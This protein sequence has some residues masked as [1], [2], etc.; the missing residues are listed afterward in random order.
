MFTLFLIFKWFLKILQYGE[1]KIN[2]NSSISYLENNPVGPKSRLIHPNLC[3]SVCILCSQHPRPIWA[4]YVVGL[5]I[6]IHS[7]DFLKI[8]QC[9]DIKI[10]KS[11]SIEYLENTHFDPKIGLFI[12]VWIIVFLHFILRIHFQVY[13]E[14]W[15]G[16]GTLQTNKSGNIEYFKK[17]LVVLKWGI[18]IRI[19]AQKCVT[20]VLMICGRNFCWIFAR[21]RDTTM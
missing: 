17:T 3:Q 19:W 18:F 4:K 14:I 8:L 5:V 20:L 2:K 13:F 9:G 6:E 21:W 10:N 11:S 1:T 7:K 12:P 16:N 15:Q